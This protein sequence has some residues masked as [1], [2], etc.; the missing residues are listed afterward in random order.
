MESSGTRG[1]ASTK[2]AVTAARWFALIGWILIGTTLSSLVFSTLP[3]RLVNPDWQL[4]LISSILAGT[5]SLLLGTLLVCGACLLQPRNPQFQQRSDF[6]RTVSGWFAVL[7]LLVIPVQFYA[8]HRASGAVQATE[9]QSIQLIK[10]II[11]GVTASNNEAE[12]RSFLASLPSP[13]PVPARFEAPFPEIKQRLL[14]NFNS[15]LNA[16]NYQAGEMRSQR[17][18]KFLADATRNSVQAFLMAI[19][20]TGIA[21]QSGPLFG[22]FRRLGVY[23]YRD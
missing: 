16:A 7:L 2:P 18:E 5:T 3:V 11:Q 22:F 4:R 6:L 15:R 10:K 14:T 13:P 23:R 9:N 17:L 12:L 21:D 1:E 19:A 8:G 20:F